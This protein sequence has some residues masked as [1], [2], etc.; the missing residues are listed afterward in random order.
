[1]VCISSY[2]CELIPENDNCTELLSGNCYAPNAID[3]SILNFV[4]GNIIVASRAAHEECTLFS[5]V[6]L[7]L[8]KY[9]PCDASTSELLPLCPETCWE[10][11][12]VFEVCAESIYFIAE[13]FNCSDAKTYYGNPPPHVNVSTTSCS[14]L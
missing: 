2:R 14:K 7:C 5:D 9:P 12:R 1:M 10:A 8:Y 11:H 6:L 13:N 4:E 3:N